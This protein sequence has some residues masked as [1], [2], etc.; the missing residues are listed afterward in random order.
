MLPL[1]VLVVLAGVG[2]Y[3]TK[4]RPSP[5]ARSSTKVS[6]AD[7]PS[8]NDLYD[9]RYVDQTNA[10]LERVNKR[11]YD[12][13]LKPQ[14]TGV[15]SRNYNAN[16]EANGGVV[17]SRLAGVE[18]PKGEFTHNNMVPFFGGSIKQNM[19]GDQTQSIME[20]QTGTFSLLKPKREVEFFGDQT[21]NAGNVFGSTGAYQL[22]QERA[23]VGRAH[24]NVTP[25]DKVYVGPGIDQGYGTA[26]AGG[27]QQLDIQDKIMPK[28][29]DD[30]RVATKPKTTFEG[31]TTDG[32]KTGMRGDLGEMAKNRVNTYFEQDESRYFTTTG[33]YVKE[34]KRPEEVLKYQE[35]A[36]NTREYSGNA[37][38]NSGQEGRPEVKLTI[39]QNLS[40]TGLRN[41]TLEEF[42]AGERDDHGKG[43]IL[44]YANERDMTACRT[45]EGNLTT[46]VRAIIAPFE[47]I[48]RSSI[49]EYTIANGRPNG[50]FSVQVP[51]K[52]TIYDPNDVART[53]IKE[54]LIHD[55]HTGNLMG[56]KQV[57]VYDPDDVAR[58]TTRQTLKDQA[59]SKSF[60][61]PSKA[62]IYDPDDVARTTTK[63][64]TIYNKRDGNVSRSALQE[65]GGYE[66]STY[67]V[68]VTQKQFTADNEYAGNAHQDLGGGH[69]TNEYDARATQKQFMSDNDYYGVAGTSAIEKET[70]HDDA[71]NAVINSTRQML[72]QSR[73]PT[74]SGVKV[75]AGGDSVEL[76]VKRNALLASQRDMG[77]LRDFAKIPSKALY[78]KTMTKEKQQYREED[79][80]DPALLTAFH[81]NPYT[82]SLNSSA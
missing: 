73:A 49:K 16:A 52:Q 6:R 74:Q 62:T 2:Y 81:K 32:L 56:A 80:M 77:N 82:Q 29:V 8:M 44:V 26:G 28:T 51:S 71:Y 33:A 35:R 64:T 61:G 21:E 78:D 22:A 7:L 40:D 42:G 57:T 39:R 25:F 50:Q 75:A 13:S 5:V 76:D 46:A 63:E 4:D 68:K 67:D 11:S 41:P 54:T 59:N 24:N 37:Y 10:Q 19:R 60:K 45:Y 15:I 69:L 1:Y 27:F 3:V 38:F 70:S 53:T 66:T 48:A 47:D 36:F 23:V 65:G 79:R 20:A 72:L 58:T 43:S 30:L 18:I 14:Q 9:S 34:A 31:R 12:R 17:E 55:P